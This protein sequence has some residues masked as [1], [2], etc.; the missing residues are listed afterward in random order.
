MGIEAYGKLNVLT[1][2]RQTYFLYRFQAHMYALPFRRETV[3]YLFQRRILRQ[4]QVLGS[5]LDM[6]NEWTHSWLEPLVSKHGHAIRMAEGFHSLSCLRNWSFT[7]WFSGWCSRPCELAN[8]RK[9]PNSCKVLVR[10]TE[11]NAYAYA[12]CC[13]VGCW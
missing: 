7:S 8:I 3:P 10:W 6:V 5:V 13:L 9:W 4:A 2:I 12:R 11:Q 1:W